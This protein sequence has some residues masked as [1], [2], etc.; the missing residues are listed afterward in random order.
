[1]LQSLKRLIAWAMALRP[2][3]VFQRYSQ[4]NGPILASGLSLTA[5]YSVFAALYVGFAVFG[6]V[7]ESD[8]VFKDAVISTISGYIPGLIDT[9]EGG[10]IDL[11][12]LFASRV[13]NWSGVVALAV[14]LFS[15]LSWFDSARS[16]VRT[17]FG[18]PQDRTFFLLTKAKDL[19][20][21]IL[22][23]A[24]M[25]LSAAISIGSTSALGALFGLVGI[26]DE[27]DA[28]VLLARVVGL[29]LALVIDTAV[30]GALFR[31]LTSVRIPLPRLLPGALIGGVALG[32]LKALG[33]TV[34][35]G[36][37]RNNPLLASFAVVLG[38]LVW[39]GLICQVVLISATWVA[40]D[41]ADHGEPDPVAGRRPKVRP[42]RRRPRPR[43][44]RSAALDKLQE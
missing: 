21:V 12:D 3:R 30:L 26:D 13:L 20:L 40:V 29:L 23:A 4:R 43:T 32:V 28:A 38:L 36:A 7:I 27:S 16:S 11:D 5:L 6:L 2:V 34:I 1:M 44:R 9:G 33:A 41:L 35:G 18:L 31:V 42:P 37:G 10:A 39:F 19:G 25:L 22:F 17:M 8:P 14:V 15:A 24:V